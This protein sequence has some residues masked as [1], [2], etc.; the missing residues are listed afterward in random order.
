MR[1]VD[2]H[3]SVDFQSV[4]EGQGQVNVSDGSG[5]VLA[6]RTVF[7]QGGELAAIS[8]SFLGS[9]CR[10]QIDGLTDKLSGFA[11]GSEEFG[12]FLSG[13]PALD[14]FNAVISQNGHPIDVNKTPLNVR[15]TLGADLPAP[16]T[17]L[18]HEDS[19]RNGILF[20]DPLTGVAHCSQ[21]PDGCKPTPSA[22]WFVGNQDVGT[23]P[24]GDHLVRVAIGDDPVCATSYPIRMIGTPE[25]E[26]SW[27]P[28]HRAA[29]FQ[30]NTLYVSG[31][32]FSPLKVHQDASGVT[33]FTGYEAIHVRQSAN[34]PDCAIVAVIPLLSGYST[35]GSR[36]NGTFLDVV[37]DVTPCLDA[38]PTLPLIVSA[39]DFDTEAWSNSVTKYPLANL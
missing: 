21:G 17:V 32:S 19:A 31:R 16:Q 39:Q 15:F 34:A 27:S 25:I 3:G 18:M 6:T 38:H 14:S 20:I 11:L 13:Q 22:T 33:H 5:T 36:P 29:P 12:V 7:L 10:Y 26:A 4:P 30:R 8:I 24:P 23:L 28:Q 1:R 9:P 2:V 35:L 37:V